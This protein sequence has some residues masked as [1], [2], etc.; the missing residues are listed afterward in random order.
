MR[1]YGWVSFTNTCR[2]AIYKTP[3]PP[4]L[5]VSLLGQLLQISNTPHAKHIFFTT[6]PDVTIAP[7]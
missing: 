3:P 2:R 7:F 4:P 5:N 6:E 1:M